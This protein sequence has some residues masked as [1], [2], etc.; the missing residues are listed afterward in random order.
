MTWAWLKRLRLPGHPMTAYAM[1]RLGRA[2]CIVKKCCATVSP[3]LRRRLPPPVTTSDTTSDTILM[4]KQLNGSVQCFSV[5]AL[6]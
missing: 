6:R 5:V 4:R 2:M 3:R 1:S